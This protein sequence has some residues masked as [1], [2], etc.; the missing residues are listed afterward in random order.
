MKGPV[1]VLLA[2][3]AARRFGSH[4]LLATLPNGRTVGFEAASRFAEALGHTVVVVRADDT[5]LIDALSPLGVEIVENPQADLG[6]GHSLALGVQATAGAEGWIIGLADMPWVQEATLRRLQARL[7]SGASMVAPRHA[8]IRGNPVG[9]SKRWGA[10]LACL[11]GDR[12]ARE[13][14]RAHQ[15]ELELI[16]TGDSGVLRDIDRPEDLL[17][18][19][20]LG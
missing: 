13:L 6:M 5:Q 3:G 4:K 20:A 2:A 14:L 10:H 8:E 1:G 15:G 19:H 17:T 11:N 12:G 18:M 9:F 16:E 7:R